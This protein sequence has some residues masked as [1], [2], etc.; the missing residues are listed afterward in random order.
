MIYDYC[1]FFMHSAYCSCMFYVVHHVV[2]PYDVVASLR[3]AAD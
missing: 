2:V 3:L 1:L